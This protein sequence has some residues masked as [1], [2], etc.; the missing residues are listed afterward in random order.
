MMLNRSAIQNTQWF[1][2]SQTAK[3][4]AKELQREKK[5]KKK[6][7]QQLLDVDVLD[8]SMDNFQCDPHLALFTNKL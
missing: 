6:Q 7:S 8:V 5:K 1:L 2:A 3:L 4:L